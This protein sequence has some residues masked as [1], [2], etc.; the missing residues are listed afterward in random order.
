MTE[1]IEDLRFNT[2]ISQMMTFVN[3]ANKWDQVPRSVIDQF[4]ILLSPFA[5]HMSEELWNRLGYE[6]TIAYAKW[7]EYNE[8]YL[9]PDTQNFAIQVNG[10]VR[11]QLEVPTEKADDKEFVLGEAKD[12]DSV[13]KYLDKGEIVKEIFVPGKIVNFVVKD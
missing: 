4:I 9:I 6:E 13:K 5:P 2:A 10:K 12:Q 7:P 3:D 11:G 8:E 1:D